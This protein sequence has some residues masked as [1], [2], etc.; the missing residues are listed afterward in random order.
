MGTHYRVS[1]V[2]YTPSQDDSIWIYTPMFDSFRYIILVERAAVI[3]AL[4]VVA[5]MGRSVHNCEHGR[6]LNDGLEC[7]TRQSV[8]ELH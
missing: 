3:A 4:R 2:L 7:L 5:D 1:N 6:L 8:A